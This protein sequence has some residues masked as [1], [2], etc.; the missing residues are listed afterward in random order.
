MST[1]KNLLLASVALFF[2]MQSAVLRAECLFYPKECESLLSAQKEPCGEE[3]VLKPWMGNPDLYSSGNLTFYRRPSAEKPFR[4]FYF[5]YP[6]E[7]YEAGLTLMGFRL[8]YCTSLCGMAG[9]ECDADIV[10]KYAGKDCDCAAPEAFIWR[11]VKSG[12]ISQ[13]DPSLKGY[14]FGV[15][16]TDFE[17]VSFIAGPG[18]D[19]AKPGCYYVGVFADPKR[20]G[21]GC[22]GLQFM[23]SVSR[24]KGFK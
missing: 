13:N 2:L 4:V 5:V 11:M 20:N 24:P 17:S 21:S 6:E 3:L 9:T 8:D 10:V 7:L 23:I 12:K 14:I 1:V 19:Q 15:S 16:L 22:A 18:E